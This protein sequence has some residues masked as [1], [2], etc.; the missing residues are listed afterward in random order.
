MIVCTIERR[1]DFIIMISVKYTR[2]ERGKQK[3]KKSIIEKD[4]GGGKYCI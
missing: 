2:Y 4:D 1:L 3:F